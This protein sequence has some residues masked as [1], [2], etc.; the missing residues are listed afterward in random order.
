[1]TSLSLSLSPSLLLSYFFYSSSQMNMLHPAP[2]DLVSWATNKGPSNE[3]I[4]Q[5]NQTTNV[6]NHLRC[7]ERFK[8]FMEIRNFEE[9]TSTIPSSTPISFQFFYHVNAT[10]QYSTQLL[11]C[12]CSVR[13][14]QQSGQ[15]KTYGH[16][17]ISSTLE[18]SW[19]P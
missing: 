17:F 19:P 18:L 15:S 9:I 6:P 10:M 4:V 3:R 11:S 1:M 16:A 13:P 8:G 14:Q 7:W 5:S 2:S 12:S